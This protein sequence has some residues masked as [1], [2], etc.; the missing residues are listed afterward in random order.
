MFC[1]V[2][3][4]LFHVPIIILPKMHPQKPYKL[5][6]FGK[7][8]NMEEKKKGKLSLVSKIQAYFSFFNSYILKIYNPQI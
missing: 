6:V 3:F 5:Y 8:E 4:T 7:D 1:F 2:F